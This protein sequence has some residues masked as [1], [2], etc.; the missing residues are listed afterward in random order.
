MDPE[1]DFSLL[2][3]ILPL[4]VR[5]APGAGADIRAAHPR[6][7]GPLVEYAYQARL[8]PT[9]LP[10]LS[11]LPTCPPVRDLCR[12]FERGAFDL[13]PPSTSGEAR[14]TEF[15]WGP[16]RSASFRAPSWIQY[17]RRLQ[18]AA[19]QA[20]FPQQVAR[21]LTGAFGEMADNAFRHSLR[22][23]TALA[24]Y[25]WSPGCFEFVVAD[26]GRGVLAS[27]LSCPDYAGLHDH[28]DALQVAL[29][30]GESRL[31]RGRGHGR[32]FR[33]L[34]LSLANLNGCLRFR[35]GDHALVIDSASPDLHGARLAQVG[36]DFS[37]F[38]VSVVCRPSESPLPKLAP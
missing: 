29:T 1:L 12:V 8:S 17:Q 31:G 23:R 20:G 4:L 3:D 38:L 32:G 21:G 35:S 10:P 28:G 18:N 34:F 27:L 6:S 22:P 37:G 15:H 33:D 26:A 2:D 30:E 25:R 7:L 9:N 13:M 14:S 36:I 19:E 16:P 5:S 24:G 11:V